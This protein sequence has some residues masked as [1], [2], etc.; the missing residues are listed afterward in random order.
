VAQKLLKS[1]ASTGNGLCGKIPA[2]AFTGEGDGS[3]GAPELPLQV[4]VQPLKV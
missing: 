3:H 4:S 1:P 2:Q